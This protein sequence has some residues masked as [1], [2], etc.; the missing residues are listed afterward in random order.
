MP[1][2]DQC[3]KTMAGARFA[4]YVRLNSSGNSG[5]TMQSIT[6]THSS[7]TQAIQL[8]GT[9][10][11]KAFRQLVIMAAFALLTATALLIAQPSSA[12]TIIVPIGQQGQA[13]QDVKRPR[14]GTKQAQVE[15]EFGK[16]ISWTPAVGEPPISSWVYEDFV[17]Y[18]EHDHVLHSV[19]KH[20]PVA[21][22][23]DE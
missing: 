13:V 6:N 23:T 11:S 17:V 3:N 4:K 8:P 14:V 19:L 15:S 22:T 2:D 20:T 9:H 5:G 16:P 10:Q 12:E 21:T 1:L 18:F 7:K